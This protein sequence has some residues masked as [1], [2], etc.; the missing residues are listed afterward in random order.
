MT[1]DE[2]IKFISDTYNTEPD[3]PFDDPNIVVFRHRDNQKWFGVI[4]TIPKGKLNISA[5]G[6][7]DIVNLK[8][9]QEIIDS[10]WTEC[11][12][13]PAYHMSKSHWISVSLNDDVSADTVKWLTN[14]SYDLTKKKQKKQKQL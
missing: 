12:I 5:D 10:L 11:G 8:C 14:I 13:Y 6:H 9:A 3:Y 1:K 4:M 7:I 2:F